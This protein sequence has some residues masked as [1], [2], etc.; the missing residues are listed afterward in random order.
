MSKKNTRTHVKELG[1]KFLPAVLRK[2]K[3]SWYV[4]YYVENP[5]NEKFERMRLKMNNLRNRFQT[6]KEAQF[7]INQIVSSLNIKLASGWNPFYERR[8]DSRLYSNINEV[9]KLYIEEKE[10]ELRPDTL[11]SYKSFCS[12]F[13]QWF[14]KNNVGICSGMITHNIAIR[15]MD[16]VYLERNVGIVQY[17]NYI[18]QG[19]AMFNWIVEK[20]YSKENPFEKIRIKKRPKKQ[21]T[22]IPLETRKLIKDYLQ[23]ENP[24]FLLVCKLVY[25]ALLRP[26]EIR[27]LKV[28]D[29]FLDKHF[30][31]VN[32]NVA[33]NH[34]QRFATI[35]QD[36]IDDLKA[37][38]LDK[39]PKDWYL[40]GAGYKPSKTQ[41][42]HTRFGKEWITLRTK[43]KLPKEMQLYS[44]RDTGIFDMLK[45][46]IDDLSVMQHADHHSLEMTTRY[47]NHHDPKLV[48]KIFE[49][50]PR[51]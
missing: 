32:D 39:Y 19:R 11:R 14:N 49:N 51:F 38:N 7:H 15:F 6:S 41:I 4:E 22:I 50:A 44:F 9:A 40:I 36:I 13:L 25:G 45:S 24:R 21:R 3:R 31:Y 20:C 30:I 47:A 16:Y 17:N 43:L 12:I 33:K 37:L 26:K 46:G 48:E 28:G 1:Y 2:T 18:K 27:M 34:N 5:E 42:A 23:K 8:E 10:K 35:S 29:V